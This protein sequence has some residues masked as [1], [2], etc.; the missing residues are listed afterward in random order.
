MNKKQQVEQLKK[1]FENKLNQ[2]NVNLIN[3]I[4]NYTEL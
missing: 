3:V 4:V 2:I 1:E